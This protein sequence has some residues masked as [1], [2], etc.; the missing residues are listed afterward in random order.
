MGCVGLEK[1]ALVAKGVGCGC[2]L[3]EVCGPWF[4]KEESRCVFAQLSV[5]PRDATFFF[6][7][8]LFDIFH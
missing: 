7:A 1:E 4:M 8:L 2:G 5:P 6:V 3:C